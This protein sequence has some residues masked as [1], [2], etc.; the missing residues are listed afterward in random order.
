MFHVGGAR[1]A[2]FNWLFARQQGGTFL[3]R[4][5]DTDTARNRP[6][7]TEGIYEA[8]RWLG[9]DWDDTYPQTRNFAAHAD[10]AREL[11]ARGLA[12]YCPCTP[13]EVQARNKAQGIKTPGYDGHCRDLELPPGEGRALRFRTPREGTLTRVDLIRGTSEIDL[14]TVDDFVILRAN[15]TPLFVFANALDDLEDGI[16]HVIRGEDH[17]SNVEKQI[18]LRRALGADEPQWGHLPLLVNDQRKK[19]SKRRDK[20]ALERYRDEGI[21]AEAMRNYLGT[22]GWSPP[23]DEEIVPFETMLE[24]FRLEDVNSASAQF[25]QKKLLAFNGHY[26]RALPREEF[27]SRALDWYRTTIV[28]PMAGAIQ[29]RGATFPETLSMTDFFLH[30]APPMDGPSWDKAM[31]KEGVAARHDAV[32]AA[33]AGLEE[34]TAA[35]LSRTTEELADKAEMKL[36]PYQAPI[37]VAVTGRSVGPPLWESLV[38]LGRDVTLERLRRALARLAKA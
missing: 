6:E 10:T 16:T 33:Y 11:H 8:M 34:W 25:D 23:G 29:E 19:L 12:Y 7:W 22:L 32:V 4:I 31:G 37:R 26:L 17:L 21:L 36:G 35:E 2:L 14:T 1:T 30:D 9:M 13:D 27:V 3:L 24:S 38:V 15:G 28:E 20:V 5:E 18:L